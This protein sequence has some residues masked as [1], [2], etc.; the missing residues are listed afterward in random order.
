MKPDGATRSKASAPTSDSVSSEILRI[1]LV[2]RL[3]VG[4][5]LPSENALAL[6]LGVSRGAVREAMRG[7]SQ[8]GVV[9][10]GNGRRPRV[11]R[12]S[13]DVLAF[14]TNYAVQTEQVSVQQ[15]LDVRRVLENRTAY[16]AAL[17]RTDEEV[18]AI[19][20]SAVALR[21]S[22]DDFVAMT[23]HDFNF[24]ALIAQA[25]RN[26]MLRL[27]VESFRFIIEATGPIGWRSRPNEEGRRQ[28]IDI[29]FAI[30]EAIRAGDPDSAS[31]L[32][33]QH[34]TQSISALARA[35]FN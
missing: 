9:D 5:V 3:G 35:G 31:A 11:G 15:S 34:F 23:R 8:L 16:L 1:I 19:L 26:P 29:H 7:L 13:S 12:V 32:M 20:A 14:L 27:Q 22:Y 6:K 4:D 21:D 28:Q 25:S 18:E 17:H 24:H 10:V 2:D 33:E 30:A